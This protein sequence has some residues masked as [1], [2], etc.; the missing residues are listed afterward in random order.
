MFLRIFT[1]KLPIHC[2][3]LT[4]RGGGQLAFDIPS[5]PGRHGCL[6]CL[7]PTSLVSTTHCVKDLSPGCLRSTSPRQQRHS[8]KQGL[9]FLSLPL[10][11]VHLVP[12][13]QPLHSGRAI[14]PGMERTSKAMPNKLCSRNPKSYFKCFQ[15]HTSAAMALA[16]SYPC[17]E[18]QDEAVSGKPMCSKDL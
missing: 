10:V 18:N 11:S 4:G 14:E 1:N 2:L 7:C 9:C 8:P 5:R 12:S 17:L 3:Q 13:Y 15:S 16:V 6:L